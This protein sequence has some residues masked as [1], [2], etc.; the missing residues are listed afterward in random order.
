MS[1]QV[2]PR[3]AGKYQLRTV[4]TDSTDVIMQEN[5]TSV[6]MP[7]IVFTRFNWRDEAIKCYY[8]AVDVDVFFS[9]R[10]L[11]RVYV[12]S[13][14]YQLVITVE[15]WIRPLRIIIYITQ[16]YN[17]FSGIFLTS[18]EEQEERDERSESVVSNII[19]IELVKEVSTCVFLVKSAWNVRKQL[20]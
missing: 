9:S 3:R 12:A 11:G 13:T 16:S 15:N 17:S 14:Y 20:N 8:C 10:Y 19:K 4:F 5:I 6:Q 1:S 2:F 7:K 18:R